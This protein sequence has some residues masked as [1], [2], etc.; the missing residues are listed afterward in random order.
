M[1]AVQSLSHIHVL[2][3]IKDI[4]VQNAAPT[5]APATAATVAVRGNRSV[6]VIWF[7]AIF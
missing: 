3:D 5:V 2:R 7:A 4:H 1:I 6:L